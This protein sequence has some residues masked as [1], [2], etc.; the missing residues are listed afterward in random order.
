MCSLKLQAR[1]NPQG[2]GSRLVQNT[3]KFVEG[4]TMSNPKDSNPQY[5]KL[6]DRYVL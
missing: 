5:L 2:G 6:P 3:S 4:Y 1:N